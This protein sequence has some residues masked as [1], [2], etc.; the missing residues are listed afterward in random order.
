MHF[1]LLGIYH[2]TGIENR[3]LHQDKQTRIK[4][5][6]LQG[7]RSLHKAKFISKLPIQEIKRCQFKKKK[8]KILMFGELL[9][10]QRNI[11]LQQWKMLCAM[12]QR[13]KL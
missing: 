8:K 12:L 10:D 9:I 4:L 6:L 7:K 13:S 3:D 1:Q 11:A 2:F 5:R